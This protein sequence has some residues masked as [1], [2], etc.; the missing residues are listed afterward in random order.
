MILWR[1]VY[2]RAS[3]I[4]FS[5]ASAPP[6]VKNDIER[7]PGV[8]SASSSPSLERD[9]VAIGGPIVQ[10]LSACSLIACDHL[11]VL[12]ADVDVDEL[13]REVEVALAVVVPEVAAL[14]AGD[15]DRVDR[16]LHRPRVEDVL[17]GVG[18][19]LRA[20]RGVRLDSGHAL[21]PR[22]RVDSDASARP[23]TWPRVKQGR[24]DAD[25]R[26]VSDRHGR[27]LRRTT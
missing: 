7:S 16:A 22:S 9:S 14:C 20:E 6:F 4:A 15:R 3:L 23:A 13:G 26:S 24:T 27:S 11:R 21:A 2:Q 10:S 8:T 12:V 17:L 19:D 1:P 18:D 25:D 5:F